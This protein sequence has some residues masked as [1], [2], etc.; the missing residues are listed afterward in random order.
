VSRTSTRLQLCPFRDCVHSATA[1]LVCINQAQLSHIS[2][3]RAR[4][5]ELG[6]KPEKVAEL[7]S[8]TFTGLQ[9]LPFET[10]SAVTVQLPNLSF[11]IVLSCC[12]ARI[13]QLG[14]KP[15]K[16][17]EL[18]S[19]TSTGQQ[20]CPFRD[21]V[22]SATDDLVCV[23]QAQLSHISPCR[24]R[25]QELGFKPEKVVELWCHAPPPDCS[26][27]PLRHLLQSLCSY[28]TSVF[29][30]YSIVAGQEYRSWVSSLGKWL[31]W[32]RT[33]LL[34]SN[35]ALSGTAFV[36]QLMTWCASTKLNSHI[37]LPAGREYRSWVSSLR[38][39]PSWCRAPS[40]R[41]SSFMET[42]TATPTQ[43]TSSYERT[44]STVSCSWCYLTMAC[45]GTPFVCFIF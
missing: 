31:S 7:V 17:A 21:C 5:Q 23:N 3:C 45:T 2:P 8:R 44:H 30:L 32:C 36:L 11:H 12:R 20:L 15:G 27:C 22:R 1:D 40:M 16:V 14:F 33:P 10:S 28:P 42:C 29:T 13:Q 35:F 26:F 9:L 4:I 34:D 25:I 43:P 38:R 39:W 18:V 41:W 19:H 6:F 37:F 24:A